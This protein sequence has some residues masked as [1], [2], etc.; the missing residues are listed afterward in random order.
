MITVD[1]VRGR[2]IRNPEYFVMKHFARFI[3]PG[4]VRRGLSGP[5]S[6]DA[7]AFE[8]T[9]GTVVLVARN[10]FGEARKLDVQG[11]G[12]GFEAVMEPRS[13]HTFILGS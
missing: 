10:P 7:L 4:A 11:S 9:D 1:P 8:N 2:V 12:Q 3:K 5:W 6:G 13:I